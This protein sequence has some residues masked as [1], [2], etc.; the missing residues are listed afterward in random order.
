[1]WKVKY[2]T[3]FFTTIKVLLS[4]DGYNRLI[5]KQEKGLIERNDLWLK[6]I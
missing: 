3:S 6:V 2:F 4:V 5:I 1:M